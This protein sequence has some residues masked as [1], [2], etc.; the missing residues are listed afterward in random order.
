MKKFIYVLLCAIVLTGISTVMSSANAETKK[1]QRERNAEY[2]KEFDQKASKSARKQAKTLTKEGWKPTG[3]S[4]SIEA[5]LD[6]AWQYREPNENGEL[7][8][9]V[10][11]GTAIGN[12]LSAAQAA[13]RYQARL[14]LAKSLESEMGALIEGNLN[15]SELSDDEVNTLNEMREVNSSFIQ[16]KLKKS[17]VI[18][19]WYRK[20][21]NGKYQVEVSMALRIATLE[22]EAKAAWLNDVKA[23]NEEMHKKL[24][25][26]LE[27]NKKQ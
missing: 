26:R 25:D 20:M 4:K 11:E 8:Y 15:N 24:S 19:E 22:E 9:I 1:T 14:A 27:K 5:Q 23:R 2:R 13:A 16:Q 21:P 18:S 7:E 6:R 12:T 17:L 3:S 10:E